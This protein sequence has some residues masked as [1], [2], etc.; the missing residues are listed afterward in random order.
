M[1]GLCDDY[2]VWVVTSSDL[3]PYLTEEQA[4]DE[5]NRRNHQEGNA[6]KD[7]NLKSVVSQADEKLWQR[8]HLTRKDCTC[9]KGSA[10][11]VTKQLNDLN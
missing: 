2:G 6:D 7:G 11:T 5:C 9:H 4:Q 1:Y 3:G 8:Y 10:H